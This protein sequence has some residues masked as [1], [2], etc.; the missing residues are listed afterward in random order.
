M[1]SV[2]KAGLRWRTLVVLAPLTLLVILA[3]ATSGYISASSAV[4]NQYGVGHQVPHL[5]NAP[6]Q[7]ALANQ[8]L[9]VAN[10]RASNVKV[11][12]VGTMNIVDTIPVPNEVTPAGVNA[13][14][15][16]LM[17]WEIHGAVPSADRHSIYALGALSGGSYATP[18]DTSSAFNLGTYLMY[19]V[20]TA[21]K[22]LTSTIPMNTVG[23]FN[24]VGYCG[25]EYNLNNES[26]GTLVAA[27]MNAAN[28]T[29]GSVLKVPGCFY[30]NTDP[31]GFCD[32]VVHNPNYTDG[33]AGSPAVGDPV[34]FN[35]GGA[36]GSGA[37]HEEGGWSYVDLATG[38]NTAFVSADG[39]ATMESSTCGVGW[40]NPFAASGSG[41]PDTVMGYMSQMFE[42][43]VSQDFFNA[44]GD[45]ATAGY[46][47][48][49]AGSSLPGTSYHQLTVDKANGKVFVTSSSGGIVVH[50]ITDP[51]AG[52]RVGYINI[53]ALT[54]TETNDIHGVELAPGN[55]SILYVTSRNTR[56][57]NNQHDNVELVVDISTPGAPALVGS[58]GGLADSVCG[59]FADADKSVYY[60]A[61]GLSSAPAP[62]LSVSVKYPFW[63]NLGDYNA[64]RLSVKFGI[65][66]SA[67]ATASGVEITNASPSGTV[68]LVTALPAYIGTIGTSSEGT[69]VIQYDVGSV[70]SFKTTM[71]AKAQ[72]GPTVYTYGS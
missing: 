66:N 43:L 8:L 69:A 38:A 55:S 48:D 36:R 67:A 4:Y 7:A 35:I 54:G 44:T 32:Y 14:N 21:T 16:G 68:A 51:L 71:G 45:P 28:A 64:H 13:L 52:S 29:L 22:S 33:L 53:R 72:S 26:T 11:I 25:L 61:S 27:S 37:G 57:N 30:Q 59:V 31:S 49:I 46:Q 60:A 3:I 34:P 17:N 23:P 5:D 50:D 62:V 6:A 18:G 58:V 39:N 40:S 24:P 63:A 20:N 70:A 19:Q 10:G 65:A 56:N 1:K 41:P 2:F 12:D 9:Y 47:G 15:G 42:P